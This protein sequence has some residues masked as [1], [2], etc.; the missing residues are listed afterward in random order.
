[1]KR[2]QDRVALVTG[3]SSG[4]GTAVVQSMAA[5]GA[6]VVVNYARSSKSAEAVVEEIKAKGGDAIAL[7]ADVSQEDQVKRMFQQVFDKFGTLDVLV[8][9]AG[10]QK[11]ANLVD[12]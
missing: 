9:N 10:L 4:I 1:M 2:L 8:N 5:E 11:D 3:S 12:K 7:Q 6:K